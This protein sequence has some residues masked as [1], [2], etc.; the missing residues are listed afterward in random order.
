M[1]IVE[2]YLCHEKISALTSGKYN[3]KKFSEISEI[4]SN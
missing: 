4:K 1:E 3:D 2:Q